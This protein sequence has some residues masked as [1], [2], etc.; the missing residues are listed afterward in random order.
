MQ[1]RGLLRVIGK[2]RKDYLGS[3]K[4]K[5]LKKFL[6][7]L[8]FWSRFLIIVPLVGVAQVLG[9]LLSGVL[10]FFSDDLLEVLLNSVTLPP[11]LFDSVLDLLGF[12]LFMSDNL[13][14]SISLIFIISN[15]V[16]SMLVNGVIELVKRLK[17]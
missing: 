16:Y 8:S 15:L 13:I 6:F 12:D 14:L 7:D 10:G 3:M 17:K 1:K 5:S 11:I 4:L 2:R 9:Y